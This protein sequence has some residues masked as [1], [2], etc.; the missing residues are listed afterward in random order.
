MNMPIFGAE[1]CDVRLFARL[2]GEIPRTVFG[3]RKVVAKLRFSS[4]FAAP[5]EG[6]SPESASSPRKVP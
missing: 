4:S 3:G 2:F 1:R 6:I 5:H